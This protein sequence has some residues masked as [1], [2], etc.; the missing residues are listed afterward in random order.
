MGEIL[1]KRGVDEIE[2]SLARLD[3]GHTDIKRRKHRGIF[4]PDHPGA[5]HDQ[6][7]RDLGEFEKLVAVHNR[8]PVEGHVVGPIGLGSGGNQKPVGGQAGDIA[9]LG[10]DIDG[11]RIDEM[12]QPVQRVHVV[13]REL[14]LKHVDLVIERH[15][16]PCLEILGGDI[17]LDPV[18]AAVKAALAPAG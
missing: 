8:A 15:V 4:H 2:E 11:L 1:N 18:R 13:A 16:Q 9:R 17:I 7:S 12:R 6:A 5:D 3:Q 10:G 14:M